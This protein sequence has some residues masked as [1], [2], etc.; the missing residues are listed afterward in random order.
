MT[1]DFF[2]KLKTWSGMLN[3][4]WCSKAYCDGRFCLKHLPSPSQS[5]KVGSSTH[6]LGCWMR[7]VQH[8]WPWSLAHGT[9]GPWEVTEL[10]TEIYFLHVT[11]RTENSCGFTQCLRDF[12]S[13][14]CVELYVLF[15]SSQEVKLGKAKAFSL[16]CKQNTL[17][18]LP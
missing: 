16:R 18:T 7:E 12:V 5:C 11:A 8:A 3:T 15:Y 9:G 13:F 6:H 1:I 4:Y 10:L 17:N 2:P 14:P